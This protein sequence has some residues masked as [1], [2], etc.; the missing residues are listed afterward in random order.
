MTIENHDKRIYGAN[1][2]E[3]IGFVMSLHIGLD[4]SKTSAHQAEIAISY[5]RYC[6]RL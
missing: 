2:L 6:S 5:Q 1:V 4:I 3:V